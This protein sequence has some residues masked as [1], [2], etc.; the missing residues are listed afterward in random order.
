MLFRSQRP[1]LRRQ[2]LHSSTGQG[3]CTQQGGSCLVQNG[4]HLQLQSVQ[5]SGRTRPPKV[6]APTLRLLLMPV[7][8][9]QLSLTTSS[10][11]PS[12]HNNRSPLPA[13]STAPATAAPTSPRATRKEKQQPTSTLGFLFLSTNYFFC[14]NLL[15]IS[16]ISF[17][18]TKNSQHM[19]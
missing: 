7:N 12:F 6:C 2:L 1:L 16:T 17:H 13:P 19:C 18:L 9:T 11:L 5:Q 10:E 14:N 3:S 8:R 15:P 4:T